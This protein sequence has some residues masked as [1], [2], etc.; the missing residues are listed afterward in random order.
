MENGKS[1]DLKFAPKR[2]RRRRLY[3]MKL[4]FLVAR[5][6]AKD[7]GWGDD[8]LLDMIGRV[9]VHVLGGRKVEVECKRFNLT[10]YVGLSWLKTNVVERYSKDAWL[11]VLV[12]TRKCWDADC[13]KFLAMHNIK[14]LEV[15]D[16]NGK[17][18]IKEAEKKFVDGFTKLYVDRL[19]EEEEVCREKLS[20]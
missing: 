7:F 1:H 2:N 11:K 3:G 18:Q 19:M 4:E 17:E 13:D 14:V 12:I 6:L 15:G 20:R 9:D 10:K 8:V 16:V 5:W